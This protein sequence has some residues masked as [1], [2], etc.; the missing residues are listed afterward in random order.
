ML[1]TSND[2]STRN[3]EYMNM[4]ADELQELTENLY[5][6]YSIF[7]ASR[8]EDDTEAPHIKALAKQL[9]DIT[10]GTSDKKRLLC[11]M[12]PQH[13]KSSLVTLAYSVWLI[14][15]N[16]KLRILIVNA[17]KELSIEFGIAIR[18]LIQ[19]MGSIYGITVS[20]VKSSATNLRFELFGRLQQG[21]IRLTGASGS[22]T[23]HPTDIILVDDPYKGLI[24]ELTPT[25]LNK[26]WNWFTTLIEQRVRPSTKLIVLHTRWHS[27][28]IQGRILDDEYQRDKYEHV[29]YAAIDENG[30]PL[31]DYYGIDFYLDK[32]KTMGE[33]QFQ[34]IYQ[35]K[36]IDLTSDFF[37]TDHLIFE[38]NFDQ[39]ASSRCRSWDIASSDNSLGDQRDYTV[40]VRMVRT[41]QD[42]YWI[43]DY[44]RGQ[45]G[46]DL[47]HVLQSTARMDSPAYTILL[48]TGAG[49][50]D[51]LFNE[52]KNALTGYNVRQSK[53]KGATKE[54]RATPLAN[55]IYDG[56]VHVM[57]TND[58]HRQAFLDEFRAFPNGKHDDIVDACAHGFN[59]LNRFED[60]TVKTGGKRKRKRL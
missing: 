4:Y 6:F 57:I 1:D 36:P 10:D 37:H 46:N 29:E 12:P 40:G 8:F 13:S 56:K 5:A 15:N 2:I 33:R 30:K 3:N 19:E 55:A 14:I 23:G 34:A 52:Y 21:S 9:M 53:T 31:W 11:A 26:K 32:Q 51:L 47:K 54:D 42:T 38:D 50:S 44:E 35:Q 17:E 16:P 45:Y 60:N 41:P 20:R 28:D 7:V 48:E 18:Q 39:W 58:E 59:Y 49:T 27:E 43:F 24:D 22:I 25:A